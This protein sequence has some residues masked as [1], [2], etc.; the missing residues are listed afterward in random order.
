MTRRPG[1]RARGRGGF[2]IPV[3]VFLLFAIGVAAAAAYRV[4]QSEA[5]LAVYS[6]DASQVFAIAQAGLWRRMATIGAN[7]AD[8][9]AYSIAGGTATVYGRR[10]HSLVNFPQETWVVTSSASYS[11]PRYAAT[12]AQRTVR[13]QAVYKR[14]PVN[15]LATFTNTGSIAVFGGSVSGTDAAPSGMCSGAPRSA[16]SS[17]YTPTFGRTAQDVL[18]S[19]DAVWSVL[20]DPTLTAD[21]TNS[22]PPGGLTTYP[23]VRYTGDLTISSGDFVQR[24]GILIVTG[25]LTITAPFLWNGIILAGSFGSLMGHANFVLRGIM[26][27][28]FGG[29]ATNVS[30]M[31]GSLQYHSCHLQSAGARLAMLRPIRGTW[32]EVL[33]R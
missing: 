16:I 18:S 14:S 12:P 30:F 17:T 11:D 25:R 21:Y 7:P 1:V 33:D 9:V 4:I 26:A 8:T 20:T 29:T 31:G 19:L 10:V 24:Q 6:E 32:M 13:Q 22:L 23:L 15:L 28:G 2:A 27:G 3:V 5:Q